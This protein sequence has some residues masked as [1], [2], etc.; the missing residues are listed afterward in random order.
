MATTGRLAADRPIV[1]FDLEGTGLRPETD[2]I[3][4]IGCLKLHPDGR[5][6]AWKS[7]VN[8]G[9]KIPP[10]AFAVHG[11]SDLHVRNAPPFKDLA[12]KVLEILDGSD[13]AGFGIQN[14]DLPLLQAELVRAGKPVFDLAGRRVIDTLRI[15][16]R[17]EP[18]NLAAAVKF[19]C[20]KDFTEGHD[21]LADAE[22]SLEVLAGELARYPDLPGDVAGLG[23]Y[24]D[25]GQ[26]RFL[27]VGRKLAWSGG[28]AV[29]KFGKVRGITLNRAAAEHRDYLEWIL[30]GDFGDDLKALVRNALDGKF[31]VPPGGA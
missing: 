11:I 28:K 19:F 30:R 20:A 10:E 29:F 16:H 14:Y 26:E 12:M 17:R 4:Q 8:P 1:F 15:F 3:V 24:C 31:P 9:V 2:R 23:A 7:L 18:R 13:L 25:E 21:A 5:R 22:A 6:E 27:D